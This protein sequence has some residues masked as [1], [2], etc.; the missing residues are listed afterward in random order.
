MYLERSKSSPINLQLDRDK[1]LSPHDPFLQV[2]PQATARLKSIKILGTPENLEDIT[3][4]L[5]HPAPLLKSLAIEVDWECSPDDSPEITTTLFGGDLS[6]LRELR[7]KCI[8]TE[9]PWR[10]MANLTS[11]TLGY[12]VPE[13]STFS[14]GH[15]LDFFE[16]A[17]R[18]REIQLR[19]ATPT[20]GAQNGRLVSLACLKRMSILRDGPSSL[21]LD[22]LLIPVGAKLEMQVDFLDPPIEGQA[23][24]GSLP[25][26]LDNL[27]NFPNF[28]KI[29]LS[30][31]ESCP[32]VRFSGPNGQVTMVPA[33]P[34][35]DTTCQV[36]EFLARFDASKIERLS[37]ANGDLGESYDDHNLHQVLS[38]MENLRTLV[39]CR[40]K[41]LSDS[42]YVLEDSAVCPKLEELVLDPRYPGTRFGVGTVIGIVKGRASSGAKLKSVKISCRADFAQRDML[43]LAKH[44]S[45]AECS[46]GVVK[47]YEES[48]SNDDSDGSDDGE[49]Y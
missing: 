35:D 34:L 14:I 27:R 36:Y 33:T 45:H 40:S 25:R 9:L 17:P 43:R 13:D 20:S 47:P 37:I 48:D 39:I 2:I 49:E 28:T 41:N 32:H 15:L 11:F 4:Q 30:L 31:S 23:A 10:N 1:R 42:I 24:S 3:A 12:T 8:R 29:H 21:L 46:P 44:V 7:L 16:S 38:L 5:S 6:S 18:L 19:S 22:H 26:S